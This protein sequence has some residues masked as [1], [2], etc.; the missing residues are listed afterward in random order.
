MKYLTLLAVLLMT[1]CSSMNIKKEVADA[2]FENVTGKQMSQNSARCAEVQRTCGNGNY[3][4]W[5]QE[6]GQKACACN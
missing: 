5:R 4:E 1:G 3:T 2:V 6:N